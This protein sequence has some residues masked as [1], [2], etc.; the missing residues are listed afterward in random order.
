VNTPSSLPNGSSAAAMAG[1]AN[2]ANTPAMLKLTAYL[3]SGGTLGALRGCTAEETEVAYTVGYSSYV[4]G[5]W[6]EAVSV[7]S[8]LVNLSPHEP[9]FVRGLASCLQMQE[10]H[11]QALGWWGVAR[12]LDSDDPVAL[13]HGCECLVALGRREEALEHLTLLLE[14]GLFRPAE[15]LKRR[16]LALGERLRMQQEK[17]VGRA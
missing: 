2:F 7:F 5:R 11:E 9:R 16:A 1:S 14:P 8:T 4:A 6:A 13:F 10:Q 3:L 15:A 12:L 17:P